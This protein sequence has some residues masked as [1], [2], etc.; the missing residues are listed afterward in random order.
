LQAR[1]ISRIFGFHYKETL[2]HMKLHSPRIFLLILTLGLGIPFAAISQTVSLK[3][4][5]ALTEGSPASVGMSEERLG[6]LADMCARAV[7]DGEIPGAVALVARHGKI[8]LHHAWGHS[9]SENA[10]PM[11]KDAIF[12]IASQSKAITSTAVMMLWEEGRFQLDDPVSRYIPEFANPQV[13]ERFQYS[14]LSWQTRPATR[15]ITIRHLLTH[16][17]GIGYGEIDKD[18]R[19]KLIYRNAGIVD[20]FTTEPVS[21]GENIRK[22]AKLPLHHDP[23]A[24]Y[25]YGEGLDVLAWFVEVLSGMPYDEFLRT[26]LFEPLGMKDTAFYLDAQQA[27]RLVA[28]QTKDGDGTWTRFPTTFYDPDF[29]IKGARSYFSGGAGLCSTAR[30]YASFLQMFLNG[31]ELNGVRILSRTTVQMMMANQTGSLYGADTGRYHG[32]AFGVVAPRGQ[33][34]GGRGSEGSFSWGGYFNTQGFADPK[35][36]IVAILMKQTQAIS[37]D[38]TG[39]KLPILVSQAVDD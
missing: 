38:S 30:D 31:G 27:E 28:V 9:D 7:A 15:E 21:I 2:T 4:S 36:Q 25:T 34:I 19:I 6:R 11:Q 5:P 8:V 23:G 26:R 12:R 32:L 13:L 22:L 29:P 37:G 35:E 3:H 18:E 20:L 17:S 14:D 16:T 10:I 1:I 39:W 33:E 24:G